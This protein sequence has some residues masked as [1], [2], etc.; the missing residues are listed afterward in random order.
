MKLSSF[1]LMIG[2]SFLATICSP[3]DEPAQT[4]RV[5]T[6][7]IITVEGNQS[8]FNLNDA[9]VISTDIS[10]SQVDTSGNSF[11]LSSLFYDDTL[12][13]SFLQHTLVLYRENGFGTLSEIA[14]TNDDIQSL[15]GET[16]TN[17]EFI[18]TRSYY[19]SATDSFRSQYSITLREAGTYYLSHTRLNFSD[20]SKIFITGGIFELGFVEIT[21]CI[22]NSNG[23]CAYAFEVTE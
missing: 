3:E 1:M 22:Q 17:N 2:T 4:F 20:L 19:D 23:D 8:N 18:T 11:L 6:E 15:V 16:E 12:N 7:N 5:D 21:T 9:I 14:I 10:N 13:E